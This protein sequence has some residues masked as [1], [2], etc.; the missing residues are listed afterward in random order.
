MQCQRVTAELHMQARRSRTSFAGQRHAPHPSA[1][2]RRAAAALHKGDS[3]ARSF[4]AALHDIKPRW[5]PLVTE[6]SIPVEQLGGG[7]KRQNRVRHF[8]RVFTIPLLSTSLRD[9]DRGMRCTSPAFPSSSTPSAW[10]TPSHPTASTCSPPR[11]RTGLTWSPARCCSAA[12]LE[13][14]ER[15]LRLRVALK[16]SEGL[17]AWRPRPMRVGEKFLHFFAPPQE[18]RLGQ[19]QQHV[20]M[21]MSCVSCR[22]CSCVVILCSW[23]CGQSCESL[24]LPDRNY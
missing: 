5:L 16:I 18:H 14:S 6:L 15:S 3:S 2:A 20:C 8:A 4:P 7:L 10:L 23:S 13:M 22:V 19:L 9:P 12:P 24:Q 1:M 17:D 11:L 21:S